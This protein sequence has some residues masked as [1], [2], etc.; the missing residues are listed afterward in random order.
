MP[1]RNI[2]AIRKTNETPFFNNKE[3]QNS[4]KKLKEFHPK[5]KDPPQN[6]TKKK[7][8]PKNTI[9][10]NQQKTHL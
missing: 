10:T 5:S 9:P 8:P 3:S 7:K 6:K 2:T 4:A 1:N